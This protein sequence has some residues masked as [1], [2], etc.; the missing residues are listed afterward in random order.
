MENICKPA[1]TCILSQKPHLAKQKKNYIWNFSRKILCL[2]IWGI[3][4][5]EFFRNLW[6]VQVLAKTRKSIVCFFVASV[7][8][9]L[10]SDFSFD[11]NGW[12]SI[13]LP[14]M[15][16][17]NILSRL[18]CDIWWRILRLVCS[19]TLTKRLLNDSMLIYVIQ[20][21][22]APWKSIKNI[23]N[24]FFSKIYTFWREPSFFLEM[25]VLHI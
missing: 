13:F 15:Q 7:I 10:I 22:C 16:D 5:F 19:L 18:D 2:I 23:L 17:E 14:Y 11:D 4:I 25:L 21:Y 3:H 24:I 8:H 1:N 20:V 6:V 12:E 9:H